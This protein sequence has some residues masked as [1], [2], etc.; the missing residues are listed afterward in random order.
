MLGAQSS[1]LELGCG[2]SGVVGL[3]LAPRIARYILTDQPY[4]SRFVEQNLAEN[5]GQGS[6]AS[7]RPGKGRRS[8]ETP[9]ARPAGELRFTSLDWEL[10]E[11]TSSLT[12]SSEVKSF[13]AVLAC[14]CVYN[15]ALIDPLVSACADICRLREADGG[16]NSKPCVCVVAQQLRDPEI[17]E[18]WLK[19]FVTSFHTWRVPDAMLAEALRST[20]GFVVHVGVLR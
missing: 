15:E 13:D 1:V 16:E 4:V 17:F 3:V 9:T 2:I 18:G 7:R 5:A 20:R 10:D 14:D 12:G 19:R 11:V 8:K 6:G